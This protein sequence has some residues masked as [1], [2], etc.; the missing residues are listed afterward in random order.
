MSRGRPLAWLMLAVWASWLSA[1][2]AVVV[3][4]TPLG[5]WTPDLSF[6][7]LVACAGGLHKKDV[8]LATLLVAL[9]R[10][11]YTVQSPAA[12][13]AGFLAASVLCQYTRR[14]AELGTPLLRA[15]L[16]GGGALVLGLWFAFVHAARTGE[17]AGTALSVAF[18]PAIATSITTAGLGLVAFGLFVNLPGLAPLRDRRW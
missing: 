1:A 5:P 18:G 13:L 16:A 9:G 10:L 6:L 12:V 14:V 3:T 2:Q 8:P 17:D 11:P 7:L 15:S 4:G